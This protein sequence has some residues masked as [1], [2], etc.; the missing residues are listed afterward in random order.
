LTVSPT[1]WLL[2]GYV[3]CP[4]VARLG[5]RRI[6][7]LIVTVGRSSLTMVTVALLGDPTVYAALRA[8]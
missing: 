4:V 8:T 7:P 2:S 6:G 1:S 5:R 3:N